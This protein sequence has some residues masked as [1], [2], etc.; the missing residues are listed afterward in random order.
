MNIKR[1]KNYFIWIIWLDIMLF[2]EDYHESLMS[3]KSL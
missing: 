2:G 1:F 3:R